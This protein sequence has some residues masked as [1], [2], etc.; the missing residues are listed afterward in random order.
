M[1]KNQTS[2][3]RLIAGGFLIVI[4]LIHCI[5]VAYSQTILDYRKSRE[6]EKIQYAAD[7][8][9]DAHSLQANFHA[10]SRAFDDEFSEFLSES[11]HDYIISPELNRNNLMLRRTGPY[12]NYL[13]S[14]LFPLR[15]ACHI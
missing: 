12:S 8:Q 11:W 10:R 4:G 14:S 5:T 13:I 1:S 3:F 7:G 15:Q 9:E 6:L 2:F